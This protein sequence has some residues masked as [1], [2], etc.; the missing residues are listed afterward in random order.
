MMK[1]YAM[2]KKTYDGYDNLFPVGVWYEVE[3]ETER[4]YPSGLRKVVFIQGKAVKADHC[5]IVQVFEK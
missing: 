2:H 3:K 5:E 1:T 4:W